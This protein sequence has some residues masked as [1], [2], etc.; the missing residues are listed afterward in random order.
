MYLNGFHLSKLNNNNVF[1]FCESNYR[2]P[3][4][5]IINYKRNKSENKYPT[6]RMISI[7]KTFFNLNK[8]LFYKSPNI[9]QTNYIASWA[10]YYL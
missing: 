1:V 7:F 3:K 9:V 6:K 8:F 10:G 4:V 2:L 5:I